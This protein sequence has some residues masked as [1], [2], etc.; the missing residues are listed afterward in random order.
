MRWQIIEWLLRPLFIQGPCHHHN[1]VQLFQLVRRI[2][3][4]EFTED[5]EVTLDACL[6]ECWESSK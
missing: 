6:T 1:A 5:N 3:G 4:D 2:W